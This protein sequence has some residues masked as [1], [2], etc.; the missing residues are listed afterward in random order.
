MKQYCIGTCKIGSIEILDSKSIRFLLALISI[1][2]DFC[3]YFCI[4]VEQIDMDKSRTNGMM[5]KGNDI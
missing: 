2:K 5:L 3:I 4:R 1:D